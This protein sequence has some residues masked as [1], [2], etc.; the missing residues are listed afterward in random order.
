MD[1]YFKKEEDRSSL[2][3]LETAWRKS[4]LFPHDDYWD[5]VLNACTNWL[6]YLDDTLVGYAQIG[7][8]NT[9]Y[10]FY[11][12]AKWLNKGR[13]LIKEFIDQQK[14][15]KACLITN[16]PIFHT[17]AMHHHKKVEVDNYLFENLVDIKIA[18]QEGNFRIATLKDLDKLVDF[19]NEVLDA[20]K[21]WLKTYIKQW[22]DRDEF[23]MFSN[24]SEIIG[25]CETRSENTTDYACLGIVVSAKHRNKGIGSFLLNKAKEISIKR[26]KMPICSCAKDNIASLI[27]IEK[28]GFR[29]RHIGL[30][31]YF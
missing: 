5:A 31:V 16:N 19:S 1:F 25:T 9:L 22:I 13:T 14:I 3:H 30:N 26:N 4:L 24:E 28:N 18:E 2:L 27:A 17:L 12:D 6:V 23:F 10:Q 8:N 29:I 21:D 20:P 7:R 11:I 15:E